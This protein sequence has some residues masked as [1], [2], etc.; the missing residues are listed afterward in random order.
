MLISTSRYYEMYIKG[1]DAKYIA[2]QVDEIKR[3]IKALK[4]RME[5]P[6]Y[7]YEN[8]EANLEMSQIKASREYLAEAVSA[9]R[10]VGAYETTEEDL[11][12]E[13]IQSM[14]G[15]V[16]RLTLTGGVYLEKKHI[17]ELSEDGA[18][19][20]VSVLHGEE[21]EYPLDI[22]DARRTLDELHIGE[23]H[24]TYSPEDYGCAFSEAERWQ[25]RIDYSGNLSPA[26][27]DGVGVYPYNFDRLARLLKYEY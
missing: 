23:W 2:K 9:L 19:L 16:V 11:R 18:K 24:D 13:S 15:D 17:A 1:K 25:L 6:G 27:F 10:E 7:R 8:G 20:T 5:N 14:N 12:E 4:H 21:H 26:F 3:G 22:E